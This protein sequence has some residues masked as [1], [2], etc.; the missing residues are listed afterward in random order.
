MKIRGFKTYLASLVIA[1]GAIANFFDGG[2][3]QALITGLGAAL[4]TAGIGH[5][6]DKVRDVFN[7]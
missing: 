1:S 2:T 5:K 3:L 4:G 6:L 7:R